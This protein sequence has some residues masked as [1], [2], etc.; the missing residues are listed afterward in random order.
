VVLPWMACRLIL[1]TIGM[2]E[3]TG[4]EAFWWAVWFV[5][6]FFF[7]AALFLGCLGVLILAGFKIALMFMTKEQIRATIAWLDKQRSGSHHWNA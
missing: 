5:V 7:A 4:F 1:P 6:S 2:L 3:M